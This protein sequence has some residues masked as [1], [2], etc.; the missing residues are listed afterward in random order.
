M[1]LNFPSTIELRF[2]M[3]SNKHDLVW[4]IPLNYILNLNDKFM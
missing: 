3:L 4:S 1:R 2:H